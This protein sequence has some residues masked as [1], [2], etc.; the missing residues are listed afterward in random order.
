M[1]KEYI[2]PMI[3]IEDFTINQYVAGDC[4]GDGKTQTKTYHPTNCWIDIKDDSVAGGISKL[5]TNGN[6]NMGIEEDKDQDG[7]CYHIPLLITNYFAS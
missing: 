6:C 7:V 3:L 2:K 5:L 4:A 1:K